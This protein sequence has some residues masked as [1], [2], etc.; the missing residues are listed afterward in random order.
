MLDEFDTEAASQR[1]GAV[2]QQ[3]DLLA[4]ADQADAQ[5][6]AQQSGTAY[7]APSIE[8]ATIPTPAVADPAAAEPV[9]AGNTGTDVPETP[10]EAPPDVLAQ[11]PPEAPMLTGDPTVDVAAN[12]QHQRDLHAFYSARES[13]LQKRAT[14]A[15]ARQAAKE[16]E[17]ARQQME[18]Q[19]RLRAQQAAQREAAQAQ[20]DQAVQERAAA[21]RD[22]EGAS[23][24]DNH[25]GAALVA[26][27]FGSIAAG[28][29]DVAAANLG[30]VGNAQNEGVAA[31]NRLILRDYEK[32]KARLQSMSENLLG[33]RHGYKDLLTNQQAAM[34]DLDADFA[35]RWKL[36][37]AEATHRLRQQGASPEMIKANAVVADAEQKAAMHEGQILEREAQRAVQA[38]NYKAQQAMAAA[39]FDQGE[40]QIQA[41]L[42]EHRAN[43]AER[44]R[45]FNERQADKKD[46]KAEKAADKAEKVDTETA[47][48][49]PATGGKLGN[50]PTK[51]RAKAADEVLR[52]I[53]NIRGD[54]QALRAHVTD[55]KTGGMV[56]PFGVTQAGRDRESLAKNLITS[57]S[58]FKAL[59]AIS[60]D[61]R[62]IL[63]GIVSGGV[64]SLMGMNESQ[65]DGILK[66]ID[67]ARANTLRAQGIA[68]PEAAKPAAQPPA[69]AQDDKATADRMWAVFNDE[70]APSK[71]RQEAV[72]WLRAAGQMP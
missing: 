25:A 32:K 59:G 21:H 41:T 19:E 23:W 33:A 68:V 20:I 55:K 3:P 24:E 18:A 14:S 9:G 38:E 17:V 67:R 49:D 4:L 51:E 46:A 58:A 66:S 44:A 70:K 30:Q 29:K 71:R 65:L 37:A 2:G 6:E 5:Y 13:E 63:D 40:R 15:N 52:G 10:T 62:K 34:N 12:I 27:I 56:A 64:S 36:V 39:R 72:K 57:L 43:R 16:V 45:E 47:M 50:A 1:L 35:A 28:F 8:P 48:F 26:I 7:R 22:L 31:V 69:P 60:A 11:K 53:E 61:D 54:V 42:G